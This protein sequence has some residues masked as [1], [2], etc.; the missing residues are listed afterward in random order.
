MAHF[1]VKFAEIVT[2]KLVQGL[3]DLGYAEAARSLALD[4]LGLVRSQERTIT[5]EPLSENDIEVI[6]SHAE[7]LIR[8]IE[9]FSE[10]G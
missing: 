1:L 10:K 3:C 8:V 4:W 7:S 2:P 6:K 5:L 9:A